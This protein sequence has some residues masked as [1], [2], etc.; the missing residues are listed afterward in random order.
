[1]TIPAKEIMEDSIPFRVIKRILLKEKPFRIVAYKL[2]SEQIVV[3]V[4]QMAVAVNKP[5][6]TAKQFLRRM[7]VCPIKVQMLNRH[8][9]DM[10]LAS[11]AAEYWKHLNESGKGNALTILGEKL[12]TDYLTD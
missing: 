3:T 12:M 10:I 5:P 9:T 1:M 4:R 7:R 11:T 8:I 2:P 6:K